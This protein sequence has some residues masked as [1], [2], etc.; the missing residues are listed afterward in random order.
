MENE[1]ILA[2]VGI[3]RCDVVERAVTG[4]SKDLRV[5]FFKDPEEVCGI[6][7]RNSF[8]DTA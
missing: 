5:S 4:V 2:D 8:R 3:L 6:I 1:D 7:L